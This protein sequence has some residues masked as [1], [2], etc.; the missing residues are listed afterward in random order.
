[1][2]QLQFYNHLTRSI[3]AERLN[4]FEM[5]AVKGRYYSN[6][7]IESIK[8]LEELGPFFIDFTN[9]QHWSTEIPD[10]DENSARLFSLWAE[11]IETNEI[12]VVVRGFI[13]LNPFKYGEE[14]IKD[15]FHYKEGHTYFPACVISS[16]RT[17]YS[18]EQK[19]L[20]LL[21]RVKEEVQSYW[22][23]LRQKIIKT[24]DKTDLWKRYV[25]SF[26]NIIHFSFLC[27]SVDRELIEAL[28][29]QNYR[30]TGVLQLLSSPTSS[31]DEALFK[32]HIE[33]AKKLIDK[34]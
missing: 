13:V 21:N 22:Q 10:V 26:E 19:I 33:E 4:D 6:K 7:K 2:S 18:K 29:S 15:Y 34:K 25:S 11:D 28:R 5:K 8:A 30:I 20:E 32:F 14:E 12:V 27:P 17:I 23:I 3:D 9:I 1:M 16:F 31:F 24:K